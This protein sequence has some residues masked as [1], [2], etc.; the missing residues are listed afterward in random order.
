ML[1]GL[2]ETLNGLL[3]EGAYIKRGERTRAV[4][5][6][7]EAIEWLTGDERATT[8]SVI[9]VWVNEPGSI[10]N[11]DDPETRR[12]LQVT[13]DDAIGTDQLFNTLM[14]DQVDPRGVHRGQCA[15]GGKSDISVK[16]KRK[17]AGPTAL[18]HLSGF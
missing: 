10:E 17:W 14:G 8:Y 3:E 7:R 16:S 9:K 5:S 18:S 11:D 13:I 12:M 15:Y 1:T 2:G 4:S 6:F